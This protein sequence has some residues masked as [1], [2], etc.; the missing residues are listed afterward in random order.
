MENIYM[1]GSM[2]FTYVAASRYHSHEVITTTRG[3]IKVG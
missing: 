2:L 1:K 3:H